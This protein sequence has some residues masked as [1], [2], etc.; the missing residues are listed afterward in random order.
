MAMAGMTV[1]RGQQKG[2]RGQ[3]VRGVARILAIEAE[4]VFGRREGIQ[5]HAAQDGRPDRVQPELERGDHAEVAAAAPDGPE[6]VRVFAFACR[7]ELAL[8]GN[9]VGGQKVVTG[10]PVRAQEPAQTAAERQAGH[11][12]M[13]NRA[14]GGR[15]PERLRFLIERAPQQA[16]F[17]ARRPPGRVHPN[18][19]HRRQ[20]DHQA[21]V[22]HGVSGDVV[23][24]ATDRHQQIV[25]PGE[26]DRS[27]QRRP[28]PDNA[29][30]SAGRRSIIVFQTVRA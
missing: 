10:K 2:V 11:A 16:R 9:D 5:H 15:Q 26:L 18:P 30:I 7:Q 29:R 12:G 24:A 14:P 1:G 20:I 13:G 8:G 4:H 17:G 21:A 6:Q 28:L 23:P 22:T 19:L 25:R 3:L 27:R